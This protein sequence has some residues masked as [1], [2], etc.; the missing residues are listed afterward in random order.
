MKSGHLHPSTR[1][2]RELVSYFEELGFE[3]FE[4]PEVDDE[5]HN[6]D[7]LNVAADHPARD[8]QDTFYLKDGRLLRTHTSNCQIRAAKEIKPPIKVVIPGKCYRNEATDETH[9]TTF[10]QIEGLY[11]DKN[12]KVGNLFWALE[13]ILKKL[14]GE[15]VEY[16]MRPHHYPFVEPGFDVDIKRKLASSGVE[17]WMEVL[18][19]GMVHPTVLKNMGLD[20]EVYS[21]FAFGLGPDRMMMQRYGIKDI[22][23]LWQSDL[24][25]LRQF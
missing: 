2:L 21:G 7:A 25:F 20:P 17:R 8:E 6:F 12:V 5:W 11:I 1:I 15:K 9:E 18:G 22:R 23:Q 10:F 16:R 13:M 24:R 19:S 3:V 4:G 14:Y